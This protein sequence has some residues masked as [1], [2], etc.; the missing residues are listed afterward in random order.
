MRQRT[1]LELCDEV[2]EELEVDI[3]LVKHVLNYIINDVRKE[4][5]KG[6]NKEILIHNFGTFTIPKNSI[7]KFRERLIKA[8]ELK[9]IT[10]AKFKKGMK[11]LNMLEERK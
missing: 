7:K 8:F 4:I 2:S 10:E 11:N 5:S 6:S 3:S 1:L 9:N